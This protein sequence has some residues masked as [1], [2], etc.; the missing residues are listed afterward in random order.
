VPPLVAALTPV[1]TWTHHAANER[2]SGGDDASFL[3]ILR[4][5]LADVT[6]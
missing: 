3:A 4:L 2:R 5:V 1:A 6:R